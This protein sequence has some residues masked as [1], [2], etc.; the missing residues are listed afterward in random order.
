M[1]A[2]RTWR[3]ALAACLAC[4][5]VA[6]SAA[7]VAA[8]TGVLVTPRNFPDHSPA[9]VAEMFTLAA[10]AGS[11]ATIRLDWNDPQRSEVARVL[12]GM[13]RQEGLQVVLQ[14]N[15]FK[16]DG[17]AGASLQPPRELASG[18]PRFRDR[19]VAEAFERDVLDMART[20]PDLLVVATDVNLYAA[21]DAEDAAA[22]AQLVRQLRPR[23]R[24]AAPATK[25][26]VGFQWDALQKDLAAAARL[27][28]RFGDLDALAA[29]SEPRRIFERQGV[30]GIPADY[31]TRLARLRGR[32]DLY[33][34]VGWPSDGGEGEAEQARFLRALPKLLAETRPTILA[35]SFLHD[36]RVLKVFTVRM[37]LRRT[38]GQPKP[39]WEAF[40]QAV[41]AP[42][43]AAS[44]A[45]AANPAARGPSGAPPTVAQRSAVGTASK[46]P[47]HFGIYTVRIDGSDFTTVMTSADREM[48][49]PR[50]NPDGK[51]IVL[52]RYNKRGRDGK[53]TEEQGYEDTEILVVNLD[54]TG[55]E[56]II[57]AKPGI[58]AANGAWTPDGKNLIFL[59]TD[60]PQRL[61]E[62]K[63]IDLASRRITRVPTPEGMMVTDPHWEAGKVVFPVKGKGRVS[64]T[65]WV[66]NPDGT[67]ARQVSKPPA[68][69]ILPG[70]YGDFDP[71][72]SPDGRQV[73]FM[74]IEGGE[75]WRVMLLD[76][77][78]GE[79]RLLTPKGVMQ[80]LPTWSSDGR[81]LLYVHVD[82]AN[83]RDSGLYTMTPRGEDRRR[84]PLPRGRFYGHSSWFPDDGSGLRARIIFNGKAD[85]NF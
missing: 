26:T 47:A 18:R 14:L 58:I 28:D 19:N 52:T 42:A 17:L 70:L 24:E 79:E 85:P 32:H 15:P 36:L 54:G 23:I 83:L 55:L 39:A 30:A 60:N 31:F 7:G 16:A 80:W 53:A 20:A 2:I 65:L 63:H 35:W 11:V 22:L 69:G 71:K 49:H 41:A 84:V 3:T 27:V 13:A 25:V 66:M 81:L 57:P 38:D 6:A 77:A 43:P 73:A 68:R 62:I 61:P 4:L 9:D 74:R 78:T 51:R 8:R 33:L 56:T 29:M 1:K 46:Q 48:S 10:Q 82:R 59:S 45:A 76:L 5:A 75:S 50:V 34:E 21:S 72:L 67:Q 37:G 44:A 40:R 64:D 12:V